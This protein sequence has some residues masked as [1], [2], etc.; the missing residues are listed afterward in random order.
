MGKKIIISGADFSANAIPVAKAVEGTTSPQYVYVAN[1][2]TPSQSFDW[3][4][5]KVA[6]TINDDGSINSFNL[7]DNTT[8][9]PRFAT[10]AATTNNWL[11]EIDLTY[12]S[13]YPITTFRGTLS[14]CTALKKVII[15]GSFQNL[16]GNEAM[17]YMFENCNSGFDVIIDKS[18]NAPNLTTVDTI[19]NKTTIRSL[20]GLKYLIRSNINK[21]SY[22]FSACGGLEEIDFSGCNTENV[23]TFQDLLYNTPNLSRLIGINDLDTGKVTDFTRAFGAVGSNGGIGELNIS[24]W[25]IAENATTTRMFISANI[26]ELNVNCFTALYGNIDAMFYLGRWNTIHLDNL[27]D[28]SAVTSSTDLF[29]SYVTGTPKVTIA[30]VTNSAVK[31]LLIN[32]LNARSV[33]GSSNWHEATVDGVLCLVP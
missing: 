14:G 4:S 20:K 23:T 16:T 8:A 17:S 12:L 27:N 21:M 18:F 22:M 33:G 5:H 29:S 30:N 9:I 7:P 24:S 3:D 32:A 2:K 13:G 26:F 15:G 6:I 11:K 31:T 1:V 28:V 19:F 25:N 10:G